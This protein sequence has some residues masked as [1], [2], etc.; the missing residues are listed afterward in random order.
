MVAQ[1]AA[2]LTYQYPMHHILKI[3]SA[4]FGLV[5]MLQQYHFRAFV[6]NQ[7]GAHLYK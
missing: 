3:L 4:R 2:A 5:T 1:V 7:M 6:Y